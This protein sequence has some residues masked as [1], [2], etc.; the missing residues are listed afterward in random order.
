[1]YVQLNCVIVD[2]DPG[3]RQEL[4]NFLARFGIPVTA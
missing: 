1:M 2:A 4:A 3:N